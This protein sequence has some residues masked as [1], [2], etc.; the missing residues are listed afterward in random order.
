MVNLLYNDDQRLS[1]DDLDLLSA[2]SAQI[3][4]VVANAWLRLKLAEKEQA[5]Q[6]LLESLVEAQDEE[7]R[8]LARELHDGAGQMLTTLLVR[9]KMLEHQAEQATVQQGLA[10][11][12]D[13]VATTI[14]QVRDLSYRLRPAALE[15]FGLA[16]ALRTLVAETLEDAGVDTRCRL[17]LGALVLP[18]GVEVSL[19]RIAQ[20][21]LTNVIR[22]AHA[23]RVAVELTI[24]N[25]GVNLQISDDGCG[26]TPRQPAAQTGK[27]HLGLISMNERAQMVG[28]MLQVESTPGKGTTIR[29]Y[30]PMP[31]AMQESVIT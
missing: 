18:H 12:L 5:R 25:G 16:V 4:E 29:V 11:T 14:E 31:D 26:F 3:S 9:L 27:R 24:R 21:A 15:E 19:Y 2:I 23:E 13:L 7:R 30:V 20:E 6:Y 17:E 10:S 1:A 28:G 22:H 8:R